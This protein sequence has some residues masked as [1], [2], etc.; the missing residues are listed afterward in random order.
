MRQYRLPRRG[1]SCIERFPNAVVDA[2]A[3]V[4]RHTSHS[5]SAWTGN[6]REEPHS[7]A[8]RR[9]VEKERRASMAAL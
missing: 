2:V 9:R 4:Q 8:E 1:P 7:I 3:A 5:E 6:S